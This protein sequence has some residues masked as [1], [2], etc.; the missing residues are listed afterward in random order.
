MSTDM[1]SQRLLPYAGA[2]T[3]NAH[4]VGELLAGC[5]YVAI[6]F[7]G[8]FTEV[9][10]ITARMIVVNDLHKDVINLGKMVAT[11]RKDMLAVLRWLPVSD[12][13]RAES[14]AYMRSR[15]NSDDAQASVHRAIAYFV[16]QWMGR[17]GQAGTD[18]E[19]AGGVPTRTNANGG[20]TAQRY[21]S[22][23]KSLAQWGI[24]MRRCDFETLDWREFAAKYMGDFDGH[25]YYLD[26]PSWPGAKVE[27][28]HGFAESEH[29]YLADT[30]NS[31]RKARIVVRYG[32]HPLIRE[33]YP[34]GEWTWH[35]MDG[36]NQ[37]NNAVREALIVRN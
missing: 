19:L 30:M 1:I 18:K 21:W 25:G 34:E 17:S 31:Y 11:R 3:A 37:G 15:E 9:P 22:A 29:R 8:G 14:V 24:V 27:Y 13:A 36:R 16:T 20:G 4:R 7:V 23:V 35:L 26:P 2:N 6:P 5:K 32:D 33:L 10:H 28:T 12:R